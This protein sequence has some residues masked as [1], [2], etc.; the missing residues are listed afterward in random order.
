MSRSSRPTRSR[1][2]PLPHVAFHPLGAAAEVADARRCAVRAARHRW[3]RGAAVMAAQR[4]AG[5]VEDE[6]QSAF[7]AA[8]DVAAIPADHDGRA[9]PAVDHEDC[10]IP[11]LGIEAAERRRQCNG[12]EAAVAGRQLGPQVHEVDVGRGAGGPRRQREPAIPAI[13][14]PSHR[15]DRRGRAPEDH[16]RAGQRAE[17]HR[18]V[19]RLESR[20]A[21]ALVGALV[22]LVHD[23]QRRRRPAVPGRRA[24]CRRRC[25]P[26][27]ARIRRHSSARSPTLRPE[28]TS[29][30]VASRSARSRSTRG[31]A[32]AISGTRTRTGR[33]A[34]SEAAIAST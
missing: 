10:A 18:G 23:D 2:R 14:C 15:L 4:H 9:A 29:E 30:T 27:P 26:E 32:S 6:R 19:A 34:S 25:P 3:S 5:L 16:G 24:A 8:L 28:W 20:R 12:E 33:P 21:V 13:P 7:G 17:D 31:S 11:V 1:G 22:L